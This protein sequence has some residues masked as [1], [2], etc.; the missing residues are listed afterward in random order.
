[1]SGK[2]SRQGEEYVLILDPEIVNRLGIDPD[3]PLDVSTQGD[4]LIV[5]PVR[6]EDRQRRFRE[7]L[8]KGKHRYARM[9]KRLAE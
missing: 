7:A 6:G 3:T 8:K 5:T 4:V 1:M 2:L 9:L